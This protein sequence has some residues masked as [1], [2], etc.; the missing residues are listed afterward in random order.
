MDSEKNDSGKIGEQPITRWRQNQEDVSITS[1][2]IDRP[3]TGFVRPQNKFERPRS[4]RGHKDESSEYVNSATYRSATPGRLA[5]ARPPSA[6]L[7]SNR[8]PTAGPGGF[9]IGSGLSRSGTGLATAKQF[10]VSVLDR[11]ITQHGI[12][13]IRPGTTRGLPMTRQIQDKRYYEGL[14]QLKIREL[15]QEIGTITKD[16]EVQN[17]EKATFLHYDKR[18]KSLAAELTNLQAELAEYNLVVDKMTLDVSKGVIEEEAK[19]LALMNEHR[20]AE[21]ERMFEQRKQ[22]EQKLHTIEKDIE[23]ERKRT[24]HIIESMDPP[25]K[26]KY[27]NLFR[28]KTEL[29]E[30]AQQMQRE[31]DQLSKEQARLEEQIALSPL[32]QEA[33]KLQVRIIEAEEKRDK[34]REE[35][36]KKLSPEDEKEQ[37][38]Q[39]I[40]RDNTDIA[41]TEA[42]IAE[43][44]KKVA[45]LEQQLEQ[46]ETDM[47]DN[48]SEK[49]TKYQ[50]LRKREEVMEEFMSTYEQDKQEEMEKLEKLEQEIVDKLETMANAVENNEYLTEA[51]E[52]AILR[53]KFPYNDYET[54]HRDDDFE[55]LKKDYATMQQTFNRL[56][57]LEEKLQIE[58]KLMKEKL[59][60]QQSELIVLEDLDGLKTRNELERDELIT[61][62]EGLVSEESICED[63]LKSLHAEYNELK[64]RMEKYAIYPEISNQ[65]D[66]LEKLKE[67]NKKIEEFIAKE[68]ERVNYEPVKEKAFELINSYGA[69]LRE[70]LKSLY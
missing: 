40:K 63:E 7:L 56:R 43:K 58:S 12:A 6:S 10:N 47:E 69:L 68:K 1:S 45:E 33:V 66:K 29:Q 2:K 20:T 60:K 14:L 34:L 59:K 37:L 25:T 55:E 53:D 17:K 23:N 16:I 50:E 4:R 52:T 32:K 70:N 61:E 3:P 5:L 9:R 39:K 22:M 64:E 41:A 19:E 27:D 42:Q 46:L 30:Q 51:E 21:V 44:E 48:Q 62:R 26:E 18:A 8:V 35:E 57:I 38:L 54:V 24:E 31:L 36:R 49:Q 11:P 65:E 15:T 28:Q 13:G 67:D